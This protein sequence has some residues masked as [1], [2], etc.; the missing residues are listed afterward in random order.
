MTA[1]KSLSVSALSR[2]VVL[3]IVAMAIMT[4]SMAAWAVTRADKAVTL[5]RDVELRADPAAIA[6]IDLE[7]ALGYGGMIHGFK[8]AVLRKDEV[9]KRTA[10]QN[11]GAALAALQRI[12]N[13]GAAPEEQV[14]PIRDLINTYVAHLDKIGDMRKFGQSAAN[15]DRSVKIDDTQA[16]TA[17]AA[18]RQAAAANRPDNALPTKGETLAT[19]RLH[20]GYGGMIFK[21]KNMVLRSDLSQADAV[22]AD[23][24]SAR[25]E[26]SNLRGFDLT[27]AEI[28]AVSDIASVL[29][30]YEAML[31]VAAPMISDKA[32]VEKIDK[33]VV[34]DDA[35]ALSAFSVLDAAV[36]SEAT[37][38]STR[39]RTEQSQFQ[40]RLTIAG[41]FVVLFSLL[42]AVLTRTILRRGVVDKQASADAQAALLQKEGE[43]F[44]IRI[45]AMAKAASE[46]DFSKRI[47]TEF[48][49]DTL[50]SAA[51]NLDRLMANTETGL[52]AV[53]SVSQAMSQG[54]L[55]HRMDGTFHGA[56]A[57]L[58]SALNNALSSISGLIQ[59]VV[60]NASEIS[61]YTDSISSET[62]NLSNRTEQQANDLASSTSALK[63]LTL[64]VQDVAQRVTAARGQA[65]A[66]HEVAQ[67]GAAV[68][69]DAVIAMDKIVDTS[70]R[71][72]TVT[73]MIEDI[74]FQTNLLA[75]NAGVEAARAGES[76]LGF[77]VVASEVRAL[78]LRSSDAAK[79]INDLISTSAAEIN[80]GA[81][82][83]A[84]AGDSIQQISGYVAELEGTIGSIASQTKDQGGRLNEVNTA[85]NSLEGV[86]QQNAAMFEETAA[87]IDSLNML[88]DDLVDTSQQ[89]VV[90]P[91]SGA[92]N[93]TPRALAS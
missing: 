22:R 12:V 7:K 29:D 27:E 31:D 34:V 5:M 19:L 43:E 37:A 59:S 32:R 17:L 1:L 70:A 69:A 79:D 58:Q 53:M 67:T 55:T 78:A 75:L 63:D 68:V 66:A 33:A 21:F 24:T 26:I 71:I 50:S 49:D 38:I 40:A 46:G 73:E 88:T 91:K 77:A 51:A 61:T 48:E 89:F 45:S 84:Q 57:E 25:T 28:Q 8:D 39:L 62:G 11:A 14:A 41:A 76:G 81:Q 10:N 60:K 65:D 2:L 23:I 3:S 83:I 42:I 20:L 80:E 56:F 52:S 16:L 85:V 44:Q 35:V 82:H 9:Y 54:D 18:L 47:A 90:T 30:S 15:I 74:A 86:T 93:A 36:A 6:K 87:S 92:K 4:A 72:S 13:L 64:S